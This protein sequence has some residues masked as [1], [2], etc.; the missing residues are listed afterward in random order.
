MFGEN[1][2]FLNNIKYIFLYSRFSY[3]IS[4]ELKIIKILNGIS[5]HE[6]NV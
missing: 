3:L 1:N 6:K 5:F 2:F 4:V